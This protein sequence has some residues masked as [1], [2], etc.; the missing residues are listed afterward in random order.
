MRPPVSPYE[1]KA[2]SLIPAVL[3]TQANSDLP[4]QLIGQVRK[5]LLAIIA[6]GIWLKGRRSMRESA[7]GDERGEGWRHPCS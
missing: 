1:V 2:G 5:L 4:G 6:V 7:L 3:V